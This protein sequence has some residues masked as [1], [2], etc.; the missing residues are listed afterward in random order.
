MS[1]SKVAT[2][3][4]E[5]LAVRFPEQV[6]VCSADGNWYAGGCRV[7]GEH[8]TSHE[9]ST[10]VFLVNPSIGRPNRSDW[11]QEPLRPAFC[12]SLVV[13]VASATHVNIISD[14][15]LANSAFL[16]G[17]ARKLWSMGMFLLW[18]GVQP[19]AKAADLSK[20]WTKAPKC[21]FG[22]T[23]W[24]C[25]DGDDIELTA[26]QQLMQNAKQKCIVHV[27]F[28]NDAAFFPDHLPS[29][30]PDIVQK[31]QLMARNCGAQVMNGESYYEKSKLKIQHI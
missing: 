25:N 16:Y 18:T 17:I 6:A 10:Q 22:L 4:G 14:S 5:L 30:Y 21:S 20:A 7:R 1:D 12:L 26:V 3:L 28:I 8:I 27:C 24:N 2:R 23:V 29:R 31:A 13:P 19:G 9:K 11:N 15:T